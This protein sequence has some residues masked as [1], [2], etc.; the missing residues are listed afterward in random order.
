VAAGLVQNLAHP[1]G[2]IT[3]V[4]VDTGPSIHGKRIALLREIL[5]AMSKLSCLTLRILWEGSQGP[6]TRAAADAAGIPVVTSLIELPST[7]AAYRDAIAQASRDGANAIMVGDNPDTMAN[8]ALIAH[9]IGAA[10][11]PAMYSL[12]E[13]VDEGGLIAYSFDL[14]ERASRRGRF[15]GL[16][17]CRSGARPPREKKINAPT[18]PN[19]AARAFCKFARSANSGFQLIGYRIESD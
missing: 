14:V 11:I 19:H 12:P 3:G 17:L 10:G 7:E 15:S 5:P 4:S 9:L 6:A 16:R 18:G 1:G 8:R 2:N 13:F